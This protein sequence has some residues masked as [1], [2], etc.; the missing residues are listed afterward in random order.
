MP[1]RA[2]ETGCVDF[3]LTPVEFGRELGRIVGADALRRGHEPMEE[4]KSPPPQ[5]LT[6]PAVEASGPGEPSNVTDPDFSTLPESV[7]P[8]QSRATAFPIIGVGASAGGLEAF[9][10]LLEHLPSNTGMAFVLV[11]H[12]DPTHESQLTEILSRKSAM[13]VCEVHGA[14]PVET[15]HVY[16]IPPGRNLTIADGILQTVPRPETGA[17]NM[18]IDGFLQALAKDRQNVAFGIILSGTASDG[19]LGARAIKAEGGITF[20]QEPASAK[21]DGMPRSAIASGTIDFVLSPEGIARQLVELSRHSYLHGGPG[22]VVDLV[23]TDGPDLDRIF[24]RLRATTGIDFT[25]YKHNTILRRITRRMALH[26]VDNLK[27][28]ARLVAQNSAEATVLAQDF[29]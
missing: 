4:R 8:T 29:W 1:Q 5:D 10:L 24:V 7:E 21:F 14:T 26:G 18:P 2:L 11:Q 12:L 25:Y 23:A 3:E 9:A 15:D 16:V 20:A 19:T 28:Y 22:R 6:S 27:D 17:R 13:P